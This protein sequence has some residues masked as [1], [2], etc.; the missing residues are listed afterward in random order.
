MVL[1]CRNF[2]LLGAKVKRRIWKLP[3]T[4]HN[5]I[6]H[7]IISNILVHITSIIEKRLI[8]FMHSALNGNVVSRQILLMKLRCKKCSFGENYRYLSWKYNIIDC[9][10]NTNIT[11]FMGKVKI[12]QKLLY[13]VSHDVSVLHDLCCMR[14]DDFCTHLLKH[15]W[16][17]LLLTFL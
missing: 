13:P 7:N 6:I 17:N 5:S 1:I 11:Y 3:N 12:K 9:D 14:E 2:I 4:T 16:I 8:K 15:N 10:W